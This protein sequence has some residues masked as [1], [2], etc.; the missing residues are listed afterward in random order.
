MLNSE[1]K[2]LT[3]I[4]WRTTGGNSY[5]LEL[6]DANFELASISSPIPGILLFK[7]KFDTQLVSE[8]KPKYLPSGID[9]RPLCPT[10]R[11]QVNLKTFLLILM[12]KREIL[13]LV[14]LQQ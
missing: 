2:D 11:N 7:M 5:S 12:S 9:L 8:R 1:L 13:E 3:T 14:V 10:I 6:T 4:K